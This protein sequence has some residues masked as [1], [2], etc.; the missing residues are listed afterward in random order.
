MTDEEHARKDTTSFLDTPVAEV[1]GLFS[2]RPLIGHLWR[3]P[4][5]IACVWIL[6]HMLFI[7]CQQL[8][9]EGEF[10]GHW[11]LSE[12]QSWNQQQTAHV[13]FGPA[14]AFWAIELAA[15]VAVGS[16]ASAALYGLGRMRKK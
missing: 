4:L 15:I 6:F 2:L 10:V 8:R 11:T 5:A 14:Y 3:V 7:P 13:N 16:L 9:P 12:I 1:G